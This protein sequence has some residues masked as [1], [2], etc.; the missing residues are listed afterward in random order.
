YKIVDIHGNTIEIDYLH[1]PGLSGCT[2]S[3]QSGFPKGP[4]PQSFAQKIKYTTNLA[5]GDTLAEY[6]V[7]LTTTQKTTVGT[8]GD[9]SRQLDD[10]ALWYYPPSGGPAQFIR[11]LHFGYQS[12]LL[13]ELQIFDAAQGGNGLPKTSFSYEDRYVGSYWVQRCSN[14][15]CK[16]SG[17]SFAKWSRPFLNTVTNGYG[18]AIDYDYQRF[19]GFPGND[20][21]QVVVR[22]VVTDEI[23]T[24]SGVYQYQFE[25]PNIVQDLSDANNPNASAYG[26][27]NFSRFYGFAKATI[28]DPLLNVTRQY[29]NND[30]DKNVLP[31]GGPGIFN[32]YELGT[33]VY[34]PGGLNLYSASIPHWVVGSNIGGAIFIYQDQQ[35]DYQCNGNQTSGTGSPANE[36]D[37]NSGCILKKTTFA[38]NTGTGNLTRQDE[39][40]GS[41]AVYRSTVYDYTAPNSSQNLISLP[42]QITIKA[43]A[44]NPI[45]ETRYHYDEGNYGQMPT[46][47]D[48]TRKIE[49]VNGTQY[50]HTTL[51]NYDAYGN[52]RLVTAYPNYGNASNPNTANPINTTTVYD[53]HGL[54]P[55]TITNA[56]GQA[57]QTSYDYR[58]Q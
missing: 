41:A 55:L 27:I 9:V 2:G 17:P 38:Y 14:P 35:R 5:A 8:R 23:T 48:L 16:N 51:D 52:A 56:L 46:K 36:N 18:A 33:W 31:A 34:G 42:K 28:T 10:I 4:T 37:L 44:T 20:L 43:G 19:S 54:L 12:Y 30:Y 11:R 49:W 53:S 57:S 40:N 26:H 13:K 39:Y 47:G 3:S 21:F 1:I 29:Y 32:G 45:A 7:V 58:F 50:V 24:S 15:P 25:Q 22:R 6:E